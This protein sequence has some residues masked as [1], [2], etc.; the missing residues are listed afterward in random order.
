MQHEPALATPFE[1]WCGS[2]GIDPDDPDA[3]SLYL[4]EVGSAVS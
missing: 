2:F 1:T 3:W 4:G